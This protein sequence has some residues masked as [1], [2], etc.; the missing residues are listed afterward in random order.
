MWHSLFIYLVAGVNSFLTVLLIKTL[1]RIEIKT[2]QLI[3]FIISGCLFTGTIFFYFSTSAYRPLLNIIFYVLITNKLLKLNMFRSIMAVG[4]FSIL[5]VFGEGLIYLF[6]IEGLKYTTHDLHT[7]TSL[8]LLTNLIVYIPLF[9]FL[10]IYE[11]KFNSKVKDKSDGSAD[12]GLN[13]NIFNRRYKI[14]FCSVFFISL[15]ISVVNVFY[16]YG[17]IS[18]KDINLIIFFAFIVLTVALIFNNYKF[19]S[20]NYENTLLTELNDK[21]EAEL[22]RRR[23]TEVE[24]EKARNDLE[25]RVKEQTLELRRAVEE[26]SAEITERKRVES[27]L[28]ESE[29]HF[30]QIVEL[31]PSA[32]FIQTDDKVV[33]ANTA[34][35]KLI[36]VTNPDDLMGKSVTDY[37]LPEYVDMYRQKSRQVIENKTFAKS[38]QAKVVQTSK[39]IVDVELTCVPFNYQGKQ[40]VQVIV[41]NITER[42]KMEAEFLRASKLESIAL[43]AGGIAHDFKNILTVIMGNV[44]LARNNVD[45][46]DKKFLWLKNAEKAVLQ[47]R[48]LTS[49]LQTFAKGGEPVKKVTSIEELMKEVISFSLS[50]TGVTC[51]FFFPEKLFLVDADESQM[52]Q[53]INNLILNAVQAMPDGGIIEV[54]GEN[55]DTDMEKVE[56]GIILPKG[57]YVKISIRDEGS[58]IE[59]EYLQKIFDPFFTTKQ[60]GTGLGLTTSYSIIKKHGGYLT[61]ES[62]VGMG[63]TFYIYLPAFLGSDCVRIK[64]EEKLY[65]GRGKI[66]IMDDEESIRNVLGSMLSHLGYEVVSSED[67]EKALEIYQEARESGAP[68]DAVIMDLTVPGGMG[69]KK[70]VKKLREI[71]PEVK[72]IVSSGYSNDPVMADFKKYGFKGMVHKP[73][74]IEE[75]SRVV[76]AVINGN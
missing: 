54:F 20:K 8:N 2:R 19:V 26:L 49:Q 37:F 46:T 7:I 43:L 45:N 16:L 32:I 48:E 47:A 42:K 17:I 51:R 5:A 21:L 56:Q 27:V 1:Y 23:L 6:L 67:G 12:Q 4:L 35:A 28:L 64:N 52:S 62:K 76:H 53:V 61:V 63:T 10:L 59:N 9:F 50:G 44:S 75:L 69:G 41:D 22:N 55:I 24:L 30:R 25:I 73:Y 39:S 13:L 15:I 68:F 3:F 70:A 18:L 66:L 57:Q 74:Q 34:A 29:E 58:G 36:N 14:I 71:D 31:L 33:F 11:L 38:I 40:A 60:E 65:K 72:T